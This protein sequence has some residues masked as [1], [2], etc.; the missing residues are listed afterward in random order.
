MKKGIKSRII[1]MGAYVPKRIMTN[2]EFE[3]MV[4]TTDE[5]ITTR[6]GIKERRIAQDDEFTSDM[7][8]AAG[9]KALASAGITIKEIDYILVATL[10]PDYMSNSTA[11]IVQSQLG[12]KHIGAADIQAACSGFIYA[13]S[14]AKAYIESGMYQNILIIASE[15]MSTYVDYTDRGTSVLF[16]D[17]AAAAVISGAG[18]GLSIDAVNLG[19]DGKYAELVY[20]PAGGVRHPPTAETVS[21]KMHCFTMQGKEVFRLAVRYM[22]AAA[23]DCLQRLELTDADISWLVPHQA[24]LRIME[25]VAKGFDIPN[26]RMYKT[27]HKYGNTSASSIGLALEELLET[28]ELA[29][30]EK[31]LLVAFGAGLTWGAAVLTKVIK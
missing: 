8:T 18:T 15:K 13:L 9:K 7:A 12:A 11:A 5:W 3:S 23:K 14:I 1:G 30:G 24:N 4:D 22:T 20:I 26:E 25:A 2:Q 10:S 31:L 29:D 17:G 6:T 21:K 19:S 28:N 16:G 27:V